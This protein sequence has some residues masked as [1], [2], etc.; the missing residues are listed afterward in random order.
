M[1][2]RKIR[3]FD[4]IAEIDD[5][6]HC[7]QEISAQ[8]NELAPLFLSGDSDAGS[9]VQCLVSGRRVLAL[10]N[11]LRSNR[12]DAFDG[13]LHWSL[14]HQCVQDGAEADTLL[15]T[16]YVAGLRVCLGNG[17]DTGLHFAARYG[18]IR[19][20]KTM[21]ALGCDVNHP[22][23]DDETPLM[24]ASR[25]GHLKVCELLIAHGAH[26]ATRTR[27]GYTAMNL[28]PTTN[29]KDFEKAVTL[30]GPVT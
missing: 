24:S 28:F 19:M 30:M 4:W 14:L 13:M 29:K 1:R 15:F 25:S 6:I 3:R 5:D 18:Y 11:L 10:A 21:I 16:L 8:S 20:C 17:V 7:C 12:L 26:V 22:G 9:L 2:T 27:Y 23:E